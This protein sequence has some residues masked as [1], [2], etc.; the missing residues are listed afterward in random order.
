MTMNKEHEQQL[1]SSVGKVFFVYIP[2]MSVPYKG[3]LVS[4]NDKEM[5]FE[6]KDGFKKIIPRGLYD[7]EEQRGQKVIDD[8]WR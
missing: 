4:V 6:G 5:V 3:T 2:R 7:M 1:E 8:G